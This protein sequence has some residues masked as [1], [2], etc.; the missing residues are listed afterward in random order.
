[1]RGC[2][3]LPYIGLLGWERSSGHYEVNANSFPGGDD[4]LK[5]VVTELHKAGVKVGM[6]FLSD[7]IS[8]N[9]AYLTPLPHPDLA[10]DAA[11]P[12]AAPIDVAATFIA[13]T[14]VPT[15]SPWLSTHWEAP[16]SSGVVGTGYD[17]ST[18][19]AQIDD[20]LVT[21]SG[22]NASGLVGVVRGALG[23]TATSHTVG[24]KVKH[25]A[26]MYGMVMPRPGSG[27][28][29]EIAAR[30]AHVYNYCGMDMVYFDGSEGLAAMGSEQIPISMFELDFF[31]RLTRDVLIEGSSIVPYTW[32]LNARANTG[33]YAFLDPKSYMDVQKQAQCEV[34]T[35]N[36]MNPELGWWGMDGGGVGFPA[37]LPDELEY[38]ARWAV[39]LGVSPQIEV[40][41]A[42]GRA[43]EGLAR[44][45]PWAELQ[46]QGPSSAL[47]AKL[48]HTALDFEM[49][50]ASETPYGSLGGAASKYTITPVKYH[51]DTASPDVAIADPLRADT[52]SFAIPRYFGADERGQRIGVRLRCLPAVAPFGASNNTVLL[53][54]GNES[55]T[56]LSSTGHSSGLSVSATF[57]TG[58][59][60]QPRPSL[61]V[62]AAAVGPATSYSPTVEWAR[63]S[64][65]FN[66]AVDLS[67]PGAAATTERAVG[68]WVYSDG[69][70][71]VLNL[72]LSS[73]V[74]CANGCREYYTDLSWKG[75]KLLHLQKQET[76][77]TLFSYGWPYN[78]ESSQRSWGRNS[79]TQLNF[80]L[81]NVSSSA[82]S[83]TV[84]IGQVEALAQTIPSWTGD[85]SLLTADM[86][87]ASL[88]LAALP[89]GHYMECTDVTQ[90]ASCRTFDEGGHQHQLLPVKINNAPARI[91]GSDVAKAL[92]ASAT[93][94]DTIG[95]A[96][97]AAAGGAARLEVVVIEQGLPIGLFEAGL[98]TTLVETA[99]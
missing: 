7:L 32:W 24:T 58:P 28:Q 16:L 2:A 97:Q 64:L 61:S 56:V 88:H 87:P 73:G 89:V 80:Y 59:S 6:H 3:G 36:M 90:A 83:C 48:R 25:L 77:R 45:K 42:N 27:L 50:A 69:C 46:A 38:M 10:V 8:M 91:G 49:R 17:F 98:G 30:L 76:A 35:R 57:G 54:P 60:A 40:G 81:S 14:Q 19:L 66:A 67:S 79:V 85:V 51:G 29:A 52:L 99:V 4:G 84:H 74:N 68:A 96:V 72:Q 23:S 41:G 15:E 20:E 82:Q 26:Q 9:D 92:V 34:H 13:T 62:S 44:M 63:A 12:L 39:A 11:V 75:W 1:M 43:A 55:S 65:S 94:E 18:A 93:L 31:S 22:I 78:Q 95:V 86:S 71:G 33:D 47:R 21:Y 37:T 5:A 53:K 70:G